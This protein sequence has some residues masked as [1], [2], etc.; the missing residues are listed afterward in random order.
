MEPNESLPP[1][2]ERMD[3]IAILDTGCVM[4]LAALIGAKFQ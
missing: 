1:F 4:F 3:R 2:T